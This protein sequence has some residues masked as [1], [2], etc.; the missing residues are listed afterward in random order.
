[1]TCNITSHD[2]SIKELKS[3]LM[4]ILDLERSGGTVFIRDNDT[5]IVVDKLTVTNTH[6]KLLQA[7]FPHVSI[8]I[9]SST[10]SRSGFMLLASSAK[11]YN[12]IWERSLLRL[13]MH[14][15]FFASTVL[16]TYKLM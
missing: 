16:W 5:V 13:V 8:D 2:A 15:A 10:S 12:R 3:F 1:M 7:R 6:I 14:C 11:P 4:K 9:I